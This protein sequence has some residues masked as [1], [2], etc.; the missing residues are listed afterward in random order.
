MYT[1]CFRR[2]NCAPRQAYCT[3]WSQ[4]QKNCQLLIDQSQLLT[5]DNQQERLLITDVLKKYI[6]ETRLTFN[7]SSY[8]YFQLADFLWIDGI[9]K[10]N[11]KNELDF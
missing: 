8:Q 1:F 5:I 9:Q 3:K 6:N 7:G 10:G 2:Q 4:A 11:K